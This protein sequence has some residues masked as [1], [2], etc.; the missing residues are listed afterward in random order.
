MRAA[1]QLSS[2]AKTDADDAT[3]RSGLLRQGPRTRLAYCTSTSVPGK[4]FRTR[5]TTSDLTAVFWAAGPVILRATL[6]RPLPMSPSD[7]T[8]IVP[9]VMERNGRM[10]ASTS[11]KPVSEKGSSSSVTAT[12]SRISGMRCFSVFSMPIFRVTCDELQSVQ[13]PCSSSRTTGPT[14]S[15]TLQSP[16][17]LWRYGRT[18]SKTSSTFSN[19]RSSVPS[20]SLP[21]T[22]WAGPSLKGLSASI[23]WVSATAPTRKR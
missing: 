14:M 19:V 21:S 18:S 11:S 13:E 8:E 23:P 4:R 1:L 15:T 3:L 16:P 12:T 6:G 2:H 17:S 20:P 9:P 7:S 5:V 10:T 22:G